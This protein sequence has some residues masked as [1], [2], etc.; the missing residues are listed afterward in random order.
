MST[1]TFRRHTRACVDTATRLAFAAIADHPSQQALFECLVRIVRQRSDLMATPPIARGEVLQITA[2]RNFAAFEAALV[3]DPDDWPGEVGHPL[4]VVHALAGHLFGRYPVPRFLASAWFGDRTPAGADRRAWFVAHAQGQRFRSLALPIEMT[5][6]M[7][8]IFL[9]TPDHLT[10]DQALRRA[11]VLGLG[12][13]PGLADAILATRL[14]EQ[15]SDAEPWRAAL[16]WLVARGDSVDIAQVR[17]LIDYLHA[18]LHV[19]DLRGRTFGSA[20]RL[21]KQWHRR[22][23]HGRVHFASWPRSR[24]QGMVVPVAPKPDEPRRAEWTIVELLDSCEL[25]REGR[26]M[27]HCVLSYAR[28]CMAGRSSI[29]SL[30]HRWHDEAI[31][32]PVLTI[33]VRPGN[34][35]IV[36]I[37]ARANHRA[38]GW[39]LR[40]VRRW[41]EREGLLLHSKVGAADGAELPRAA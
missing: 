12:G 10:I 17:P 3:R 24:W 30:R 38:T 20:M 34:G 29:W 18:N 8:H 1:D 2:L 6:R 22:L 4:R 37:R 19:V 39:P 9:H 25:W 7:E 23:G 26:D 32:R 15:F 11:E 28:D 35:T 14:G 21:V 33:E 36:Q 41:A 5:R 16:V 27:Y 40:L 31:G 13:T